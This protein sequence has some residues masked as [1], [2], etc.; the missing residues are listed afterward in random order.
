M[1]S[2][3][4]TMRMVMPASFSDWRMLM[5]SRLIA[6]SRLPVG[7]SARMIEGAFTSERAMATRCCSPPDSSFGVWCALP[8]R[9]T[10][11][12]RS[13][14]GVSR[15][16]RPLYTRGSS[17]LCRAVVRD[18]RLKPWNT[19]PMEWLRMP[20]SWSSD[21]VATSVPSRKYD[22]DVGWSRQ[23][24]RLRKVDLPEPEGPMT[25]TNSP[26]SRVSETPLSAGTS[27]RPV[28]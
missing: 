20:A 5:I 18:S 21:R 28:R 11:S 26:R 3:W 1:S 23:P 24:T 2:S 9:P 19:K 10:A 6:E 16:R 22:P 4:V 8:G 12:S 15:L 7:S 14:A 13:A 25:A 17:T 27:T